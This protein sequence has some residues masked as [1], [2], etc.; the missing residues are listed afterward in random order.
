MDETG[1][2]VSHLVINVIVGN[3]KL[4]DTSNKHAVSDIFV[5]ENYNDTSFTADIA[6]LKVLKTVYQQLRCFMQM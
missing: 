4:N 1:R 2:P 3:L 6:L 5:H